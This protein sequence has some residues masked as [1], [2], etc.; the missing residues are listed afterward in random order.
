MIFWVI[1]LPKLYS[2]I[3]V[4]LNLN[5]L[6]KNMEK[7]YLQYITKFLSESVEMR[8]V[9]SLLKPLIK[10]DKAIKAVVFDIYGT[11]LIS[12]SGDIDEFEISTENLKASFDAAGIELDASLREPKAVLAEML[13]SFKMLIKNFHQA[14]RSEDMSYPEIDVLNIWGQI[15]N[16]NVKNNRLILN[17]LLCIK[18][19]TFVFEVLSNRVYPM[20]GMNDVINQLADKNLPLG[21]ISNA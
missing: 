9:P 21:I 19:F 15:I 1:F 16:D 11:I 12:A 7:D 4:L 13:E 3:K 18:C 14:E 17:G 10:V 2:K 6:W 5:F 20:P 8:P